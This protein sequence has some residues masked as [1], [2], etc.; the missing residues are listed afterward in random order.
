MTNP[1]DHTLLQFDFSATLIQRWRNFPHLL[2]SGLILY[3]TLRNR[4]SWKWNCMF[5]ILSFKS[6]DGSPFALLECCPE[7]SNKEASWDLLENERPCAEDPRHLPEELEPIIRDVNEAILDLPTQ[8]MLWSNAA[9]RESSGKTSG[10]IAQFTTEV[11][12]I[13][14]L[15]F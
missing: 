15:L 10:R 13:T 4:M 3:L 9:M 1:Y 11:R 2:K 12:E 6:P 7:A 5:C 8:L 14:W